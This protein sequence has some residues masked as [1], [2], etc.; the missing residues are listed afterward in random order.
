MA[1]NNV[2]VTYS[3]IVAGSFTD[4]NSQP[5]FKPTAEFVELW[6]D[7]PRRLRLDVNNINMPGVGEGY[8]TVAVSEHDWPVRHIV[9]SG[10]ANVDSTIDDDYSAALWPMY[11]V[12][13]PA[14]REINK[15][16]ATDIAKFYGTIDSPICLRDLSARSDK[17]DK[18]EYIDVT[19]DW[20]ER[21]GVDA[22]NVTDGDGNAITPLRNALTLPRAVGYL[23]MDPGASSTE[24][25]TCLK[26]TA[27]DEVAMP[28]FAGRVAPMPCY[29][30]AKPGTWAGAPFSSSLNHDDPVL[31]SLKRK[32]A[33]TAGTNV[34]LV[35]SPAETMQYSWLRQV[36][37]ET[38]MIAGAQ[39]YADAVFVTTA[40]VDDLPA[41]KQRVMR[42]QTN[43]LL[44]PSLPGS[45]NRTWELQKNTPHLM[46]D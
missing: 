7:A 24:E 14:T 32:E 15:W 38:G 8:R 28:T 2:K 30:G 36:P 9:S 17:P 45:L 31:L 6:M 23:V 33:I 46:L 25:W 20:S 18:I 4:V 39:N 44:T 22:G 5:A 10:N 35:V 40:R 3:D 37:I 1:P 43:Q 34:Q 16:F 13:A 21:A 29:F 12:G 27:S 26:W 19:Q 42:C 41:F 11:Q